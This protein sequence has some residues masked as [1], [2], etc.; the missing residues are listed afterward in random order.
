MII[1]IVLEVVLESPIVLGTL[2][3]HPFKVIPRIQRKQMKSY[4]K[5]LQKKKQIKTKT[6]ENNAGINIDDNNP[7]ARRSIM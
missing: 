4:K 5:K 1:V 2:K 6:E 7:M 3:D